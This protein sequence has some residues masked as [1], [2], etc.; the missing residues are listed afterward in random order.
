LI[1]KI[2]TKFLNNVKFFKIRLIGSREKRNYFFVKDVMSKYLKKYFSRGSQSSIILNIKNRKL[3][4][5]NLW[6]RI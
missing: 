1:T 3:I 6:N 4:D 2:P 5:K